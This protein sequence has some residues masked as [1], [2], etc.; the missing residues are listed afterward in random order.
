MQPS[1]PRFELALTQL[2]GSQWEL[3]EN[4]CSK[5]L[6]A[7][8][9]GVRTMASP[10]G[11]RGRDA[12]LYSDSVTPNALFQFS[13]RSDWKQKISETLDRI[14][15]EF[16]TVN[17]VIFMTNQ[18]VGALGDNWRAKA[19]KLDIALDI[20]DKSW[21][22]DRVGLDEQRRSAAAELAAAIVDPYLA[23]SGVISNAPGLSGQEARTALVYLEMQSRDEVAE[24]GLTKLSFEALVRCSLRGTDSTH[25]KTRDEIYNDI[26]VLLPQHSI[27]Q[28]KP[29]IDSALARL[30]K[31]VVKSH[32]G[33]KEFHIS[34]EEVEET[35][36]KAAALELLNK[37]F[38]SDVRD[39]VS[40]DQKI[41]SESYD[42][43]IGL[44]RKCIEVY[45][46]K[47]GEEFAQALTQD[48][49]PPMHSDMIENIAI[50]NSPVGNIYPGKRWVDLIIFSV[51]QTLNT[52]SDATTELLRLLSTSYTLFSFLSAV[53]DV[54][55]ATKKLF[56]HG[57]VWL[58]TSVILPVLAEHALSGDMRPFTS[59]MNSL[60]STGTKLYITPGVIEEVERHLNLCLTYVRSPN[61][62]GRVPYLFSR[63]VES[64]RP[65][66]TFASWLEGIAGDYR[67]LDDIADFLQDFAKI[68]VAS[69]SEEGLDSEVIDAVRNYWQ[70]VQDH[71]R[72]EEGVNLVAYRL[73]E[74]DS[75]N[76]LS[77]IS[78]RRRSPGASVLGYSDWLLT[79][80]SAAWNLMNNVD[81]SVQNKILHAPLI[82][83]DFLFKY[84]SF[85]PRRDQIDAS[86]KG[87]S[88]IFTASVYESIPVELVSVAE[89]VRLENG[90]LPERIIQ[91]RIRD[92][93]D[94]QK[95]VVGAAQRAGLENASGA[96]KGAL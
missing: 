91:R 70:N 73:A 83:L 35:K 25:R 61:W 74:H 12:E 38:Y 80:D 15:K 78:K 37:S 51:R 41:S 6:A 92:E 69:P 94:R 89:Q 46:F 67:P 3:F 88:R 49:L 95:A 23:K 27:S 4:L 59:L 40:A 47:L 8:F 30:N 93:L 28:L 84:L 11:D 17:R 75:E 72:G 57:T 36:D 68:E 65:L 86:G 77:A 20:R 81:R 96:F 54:Q 79:L 2:K 58:D 16:T 62:E 50:E 26:H 33:D 71:R 55:K 48:K 42:E 85:G 90:E 87:F 56:E 1:R 52:P 82:S 18:E 9:P 19:N 39:I 32:N 60:H 10:G 7:E 34:F 44:V 14:G 76:Y 63:F 53:P 43:I 5:Y 29:F 45:F 31:R 64:G 22:L 13:V 21:F 66:T 24:K